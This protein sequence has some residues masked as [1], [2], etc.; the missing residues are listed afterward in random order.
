[1]RIKKN[2]Y[3]AWTFADRPPLADPREPPVDVHVTLTSGDM[4]VATFY[5]P[6]HIRWILDHPDQSLRSM[7]FF[8]DQ[9]M[10]IIPQYDEVSIERAIDDLVAS[11]DLPR[12]FE[13]CAP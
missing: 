12:Y 4:Y 13:K 1:M 6:E 2:N 5:T 10:V 8:A 3:V 9:S 11:G 7:H